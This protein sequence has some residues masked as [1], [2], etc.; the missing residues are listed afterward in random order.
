MNNESVYEER[1]IAFIDI[2][3]FREHI[4]RSETNPQH[5]R[6]IHQALK[7]ISNLKKENDEGTLSLKELG[8]EVSVFSDSIVISYP[9]KIAG[10]FFYLILDI[11][12]LQL[13]MMAKGILVRGGITVGELFHEDNTVFGPAMVE[14]YEIE[15]KKAIYPRVI[16]EEKAIRKAMENPLNP[17]LLELDH[18]DSVLK[19]DEDHQM[20]INFLIQYQEV[21]NDEVYFELLEKVRSVIDEQLESITDPKVLL[22]Y[23][24]L[25][26]YYNKTVESFPRLIEGGTLQPITD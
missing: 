24:W 3:G 7:Y 2:L 19:T 8:T 1:F 18:I 4:R 16:V 17:P 6:A 12:Y 13:D 14:A 25:K 11:V 15:S 20:F 21:N 22:K 10:A 5:A 23:N 9:T 26:R